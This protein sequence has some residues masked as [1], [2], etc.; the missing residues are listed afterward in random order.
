MRI[1]PKREADVAALYQ[2]MNSAMEGALEGFD[3]EQLATITAF[4]ER[5][6]EAGRVATGESEE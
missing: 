5:T 6:A 4:L 3:E 1:D 2:G